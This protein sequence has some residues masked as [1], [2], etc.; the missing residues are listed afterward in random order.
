MLQTVLKQ[1]DIIP[2]KMQSRSLLEESLAEDLA[3]NK[4][5]SGFN[6]IKSGEG[7]LKARLA[8]IHSAQRSLDLQYY[9]INDDVTSNLLISSILD[10]AERN[11]QVRLL[12]DDISMGKITKSLVALD[13]LP[14]INVRIFNPVTTLDQSFPTRFVAFFVNLSRATK[15]MHNKTLIADNLVSITGGR[16]LGDEYFDA[17]KE[18]EFKDI[19]ILCAGPVSKE[20]SESFQDYW[21]DENSYPIA[22][23]YK[24]NPTKEFIQNL[25]LR[26][27]KNRDNELK[28]L[29]SKKEFF[30]NF[31]E[32]LQSLEKPLTWAK[33]EFKADKPHKVNDG[34]GQEHS[35]PLDAL[36]D[37][38]EKA[39]E[40]FLI[41]SPYFVPKESGVGWLSK[42]QA[43]GLRISV[44][45]NSLSS[46]DVVAVHSGYRRY[47]KILL[48]NG[49][50]LFEMKSING[51]RTKQR[52]LGRKSPSYASLH[53]K[54]YVIDKKTSVIGSMNFDPRS[55]LLNTEVALVVESEE[56]A[57]ELCDL[58]KIVT[59]PET[60]YRLTLKKWNNIVWTTNKNR[61]QKK[62]YLEP[63]ASIW[64]RLQVILISLLPVENQL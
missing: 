16:N 50:E 48:Q 20:I 60:S 44:I 7:S 22:Q 46:T 61:K 52:L 15:R 41:V 24:R 30:I 62:Y 40:E 45:T 38:C 53:A 23:L 43:K 37:I 54:V 32:Y 4:G 3:L 8:L 18:I 11:V 14:N 21:D 27:R 39:T 64:R 9:A 26:L 42:L 1:A 56:M 57:Q 31:D 29:K 35:V 33:A 12:I 17:H 25:R 6:L 59:K 55:V 19:D 34:S 47:R 28:D 58:Y 2:H 36:V 63:E 13:S 51:R 5:K 49:I 10:A